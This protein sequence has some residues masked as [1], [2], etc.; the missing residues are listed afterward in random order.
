[1]NASVNAGSS[2]VAWSQIAAILH[3]WRWLLLGVALVVLLGALA[4]VA[5]PLLIQ[6]VIDGQLARRNAAGLATLA[7]FYLLAVAAVQLFGFLTNY[8][9]ALAA[10]GALHDLRVRLFDHL[11]RLPLSYYDQ[12]PLGDS[13]SRCTADIDT[14]DTLFSSGVAKLVADLVRLVTVAGAMILLSPL[15][16]LAAAL[17]VPP[18]VLVTNFF[19]IRVRDAERAN[20]HAV[21]LLNTHLQETFGGV[22]V[23]RAFGQEKGFVVRFRGVLRVA[24]T[25]YNHATRYASLYP[26]LMGTLAAIA[27]AFL[28]WI[29]TRSWLEAWIISLGTLTAFVLLFRSF[30]Q[31]ITA[32]GDEWQTVQ[33]ALSGLERI[34]AVLALPTAVEFKQEQAQVQ[35][36]ARPMT[37]A[38]STAPAIEVRNVIFGYQPDQPVLQALSFDVAAG[39]QVAL[40]GRTGAGKSS[41]LNLLSGLYAPWHGAVR[42]V[43][44]DPYL[45]AE[46][47][48]RSLIGVAP[49]M[50]QLFSGSVWENLTLGDRSVSLAEVTLAAALT[51][52]EALIDALPQ[53]YATVLGIGGNGVQL[54]AGQR[55]LLTLTRALVWQ[56]P[57]LLLDEAT[58][59]IDSAGEAALRAAL[60]AG[61]EQRAV[62]IVAHRLATARSTDRVIVLEAGCIIEEGAPAELIRR[63]GRFAALLELE[64]AG[65]DWRA[66]EAPLHFAK[67]L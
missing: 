26:P 28:L 7:L 18:L 31:P 58:A 57:V 56:P 62:L 41:V 23:I 53:G 39:E 37:G 66:A 8:L 64:A 33:S 50:T 49:Q 2:R 19:R 65:W 36:Y 63:G 14:V 46:D 4:E 67:S 61:G 22:E 51:G 10:Q 17:V 54:S 6:R 47:A 16:A 15:L 11:Q 35:P 30:F 52:A 24:L 25:A 27:T 38:A 43:G 13:I 34:F 42:V 45:L 44:Y 20:R 59:A 9:T 3:P 29:G 1:M 32:L 5:P 12:T 48:R 55:Q 60:R 21:G 40:V